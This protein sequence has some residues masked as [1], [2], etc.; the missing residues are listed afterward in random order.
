MRGLDPR[1]HAGTGAASVRGEGVDGRD[2]PGQ[3]EIRRAISLQSP[4]EDIPRTAL[5]FCDNDDTLV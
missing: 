3:D 5:R 2:K 1:I 4:L